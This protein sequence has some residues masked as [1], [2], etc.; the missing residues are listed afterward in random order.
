MS[1]ELAMDFRWTQLGQ[2]P[3]SIGLSSE[4]VGDRMNIADRKDLQ[5]GSVHVRFQP[6]RVIRRF[7]RA[8]VRVGTGAHHLQVV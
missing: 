6:V 7:P 1:L 8:G 2:L 4:A 5:L 3:Q